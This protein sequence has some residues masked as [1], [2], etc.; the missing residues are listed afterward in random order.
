MNIPNGAEIIEIN[1]ISAKNIIDTMLICQSGESNAFRVERVKW[2]FP[3]LLYS[4]YKMNDNFNVIYKSRG[5]LTED[6]IQGISYRR[7]KNLGNE[8][9]K[10]TKDYSAKF[11]LDIKTCII[12]FREFSELNK[13]HVFLDTTFSQIKD[14]GI[15][16][17][18]IDLRNNSG[19]NSRLGDEF[20]QYIAKEPFSQYGKTIMKVSRHLKMLWKDYFLSQGYIDST[21]LN[22]VLSIPNGSIIDPDEKLYSEDEDSFISL[23]E[24][25]LRYTGTIYLLTSPATF[26]SAADFAWCFKHYN[27]GK[28][29][30]EETGGWGLCYGDNVCAE[31]PNSRIAINVSCKLFYDIGAT[32]K[33]TH[34]V[35]PDYSVKSEKALDYTLKLIENE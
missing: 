33:S 17:L 14:K 32:E 8:N 31:L 3:Q 24:N 2:L 27:M 5:N 13:F 9:G 35:I 29:V 22:K 34:G 26:S 12:D 19:G 10:Q 16:Y 11:L 28:V 30:G 21:M 6:T 15:K 4:I 25:P 20:F 1:G 18:V 23:R 7:Y